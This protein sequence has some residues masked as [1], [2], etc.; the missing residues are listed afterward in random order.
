MAKSSLIKK[1]RTWV[2]NCLSFH[3]CGGQWH[4]AKDMDISVLGYFSQAQRF[5]AREP[6]VR[7]SI[8]MTVSLFSMRIYS[9]TTLQVPVTTRCS[10][11]QPLCLGCLV[12]G[13]DQMFQLALPRMAYK[14]KNCPRGS[15]VSR[16]Y[17]GT[18]R[19]NEPSMGTLKREGSLRELKH[20]P[21]TLIDRQSIVEHD[22]TLTTS[23]GSL[24]I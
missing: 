7:R 4:K 11:S 18:F 15:H 23:V 8:F 22:G 12:A 24:Y 17:S 6:F 3:G 2:R 5:F 1:T 14:H 10:P 9:V 21:F 16:Y 13:Q 20:Q 19:T